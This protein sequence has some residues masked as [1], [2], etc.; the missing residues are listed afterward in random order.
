VYFQLRYL[1]FDDV[2]SDFGTGTAWFELDGAVPRRQVEVYAGSWFDS[3]RE[4]HLELGLGLADQPFAPH[5][6]GLAAHWVAAEE[7]E[8]AWRRSAA[9]YGPGPRRGARRFADS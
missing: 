5:F 8:D 4:Y 7:F 6:L 3:R 2:E 9:W 1:R